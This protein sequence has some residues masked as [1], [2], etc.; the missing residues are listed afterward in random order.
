M[1]H[2]IQIGRVEAIPEVSPSKE[3]A[4]ISE[5]VNQIQGLNTSLATADSPSPFA[6]P[7]AAQQAAFNSTTTSQHTTVQVHTHVHTR[8]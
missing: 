3:Q 7:A 2:A 4:D 5:L 8:K 1:C 6:Q